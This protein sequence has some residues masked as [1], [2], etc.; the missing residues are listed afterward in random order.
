MLVAVLSQDGKRIP[1]QM[2]WGL[3]PWWTK[4]I[5]VGFSSINPRAETVDTARAFRDAGAASS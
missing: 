5:K 2:R 4:N 3:V 1:Q